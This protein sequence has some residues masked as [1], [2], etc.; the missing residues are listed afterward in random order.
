M[1]LNHKPCQNH[2]GQ[3]KA[4][5]GKVFDEFRAVLRMYQQGI[6]NVFLLPMLIDLRVV[7]FFVITCTAGFTKGQTSKIK[8]STRIEVA[9]PKSGGLDKPIDYKATDSIIF[10]I[11]R[12]KV[13]LF[14]QAS[15]H[16]GDIDLTAYYIEVDLKKKEIY[17]KG[18]LDSN[19]KYGFLPILKDGNETYK[20]D[21]MRYNSG[22]KKGRVYGLHLVQDEVHIHLTKVLKQSDGSFVGE[23]GQITTCDADQPHFYFNTS[24]IKVIPN[25]KVLFGSANLVVEDV[26]TPLAVPFGLAPIK[27]GRRNGIL[28]PAYGYNYANKSFYLQKLGYYTGLGP[29]AD[30][31]LSTDAYLNGD[32]RAGIASNFIKRYKYR[33]SINF[34]ASRFG[35]G[36]ERT[37]PGFTR[38]LDFSLGS[39][40]GFDSKY[41][42]GT[43]LNGDI[44]IQTGNFNRLN[45]RDLAGFSQN[46]F[47]SSINFGHNFLK[48][49]ITFNASARHSQNTQ[50]HSFRLELPNVVV[51]V[52]RIT[53]FAKNGTSKWYQQIGVGYNM[54]FSNVLNTIDTILFSSRGRD[55]FKNLQNGINHSL[56]TG[57]TFKLLQG[58]INVSPT[59]NYS[60]KWYFSTIK[61]S[62]DTANRREIVANEQGFYRMQQYNAAAS[63][64][65]NIYGTFQNLN[66]GK[67]RAIR[68][69]ITP[70]VSVGYAPEINPEKLGWVRGYFNDTAKTKNLVTYN[71]FEKGIN[72]YY[73]QMESGS[74]GFSIS[75]NLQGKKVVSIDSNGKEKLD[76]FNIIDALNI[77]GSYNLLADSFNLSDINTSL[78]TV[79]LQIFNITASAQFSPYA[80]DGK[81]RRLQ[82]Y[83]IKKDYS[84]LRFVNF[85][86]SL[87]T[88]LNPEKFKRNKNGESKELNSKKGTVEELEALRKNNLDY[89]NFKIPWNINISYILDYNKDNSIRFGTPKLTTHRIA[90]GGDVNLTTEWKIGYQTGY[91]LVQKQIVASQ[92]TISRNLHC[93]Q[94]D[95]SWVPI[96]GNKNWVFTLRPKSSLL[97]D[98]KLNKRVYNNPALFGAY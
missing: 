46:Q 36:T 71:I 31:T 21:S 37:S 1:Y 70:S 93:W 6:K 4:S 96:G 63:I 91:D 7:A 62:W 35:N 86:T 77:S 80:I 72:G 25:N 52:P 23:H 42:P 59:F 15:L 22:S 89:Y 73:N 87:N 45:S 32:L 29:N 82:E 13:F 95:F 17:A 84:P 50:T 79:L 54:N 39:S 8:D 43:I 12:N 5:F 60:E 97:Q 58:T 78:N 85:N 48:N 41:L 20:A 67:L 16:Y 14:N 26:P 83:Q 40:F 94:L 61:K 44:H 53:P 27:K 90:I 51:G 49:K 76:K 10:D 47:N 24:K 55:E 2:C 64:S 9:K 66:T 88:Q 56:S 30:L 28:F 81:G 3:K 98:L 75:N 65:T 19:G 57:T 68:H 34:N 38:N 11:K 74:I 69:T 33:G 92:F 18:G